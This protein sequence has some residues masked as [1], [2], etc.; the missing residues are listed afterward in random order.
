MLHL[1]KC[2]PWSTGFSYPL[3]PWKWWSE[4]TWQTYRV[5]HSAWTADFIG[6][7]G[8]TL[9]RQI[10]EGQWSGLSGLFNQHRSGKSEGRRT[11]ATAK[12]TVCVTVQET[13]QENTGERH[14][15]YSLAVLFSFR[16][17]TRSAIITSVCH[18]ERCRLCISF[19][20]ELEL[21]SMEARNPAMKH[22]VPIVLGRSWRRGLKLWTILL[23]Q[24]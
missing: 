13:L 2:P 6:I 7:G 18:L 3:D 15:L 11:V 12:H 22:K 14:T 23:S 1:C 5:K 19:M 10:L 4:R 16:P 24:L 17:E 9:P 21:L 20:G 8:G